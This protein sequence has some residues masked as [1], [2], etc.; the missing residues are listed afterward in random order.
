MTVSQTYL[1]L[2]TCPDEDTARTL[3]NHLVAE[4]L[5][6]CINI[7]PGIHSV[8]SWQQEIRVDSEVLLIIKTTLEKYNTLQDAILAYHPYEI[9]EIIALPITKGHT[10]YLQWL[11]DSV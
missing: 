3:A 9:P 2:C 11:S 5:A 7:L 6:A 10:N 8:Y 1:I 4:K